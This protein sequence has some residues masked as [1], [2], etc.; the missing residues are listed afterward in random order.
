MSLRLRQIAL[1]ASLLLA[2]PA[3][4]AHELFFD[5]TLSGAAV[6]PPNAS[7]AIGSVQIT[8]DLDLVTMHIVA[9]FSGL[10]GLSAAAH[11]HG[12][13]AQPMMGVAAVALDEPSLPGFPV[14][15][16]QGDYTRTIDLTLASSYSPAFI[17]ASGGT[18]SDALNAI[19]NGL[20]QGRV[21]FDID[22]LA[23]PNGEIRGFPI[24][25]HTPGDTN[26]DTL[27]TVG[28]IGGFVLA[29]TD[30]KAYVAAFPTCPLGN[31]DINEDGS[32]TVGDIGPFVQLLSGA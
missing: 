28:D 31:A 12:L 29:L 9:D 23:F 19:V 15:L 11:L 3:A 30:P 13:T 14:E 8:V 20:T 4:L 21:Y 17:A 6:E 1:A 27:I 22:T 32:V 5:A 18:V 26:C 7:P 10:V 2:A 16:L 25:K 24:P